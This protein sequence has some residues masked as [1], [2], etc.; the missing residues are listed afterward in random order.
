M[1]FLLDALVFLGAAILVVPVCQRLGMSTVLGYLI[2][3]LIIGPGVLGLIGE[4]KAADE[5]LHFAEIGV[6]L[7]LFVIGLELQPR[8]LWVMRN[9]VFGLGSLQIGT[10]TLVI[11]GLML[12][13]FGQT[14]Q[15]SLL[16]GFALALSSTAFVLQLLAERKTLNQPYGRASFA[17]LL[18]QDMAVIPA[19]AAL[20]LINPNTP[21]TGGREDLLLIAVVV[22]GLFGARLALRPLLRFV[23]GTGIRELFTAAALALVVGAA[24]TMQT[25]GLSMGL[26][27]FIAGMMVADSEYRHQLE[28]DVSPFKGMLLGLFFMAVGMS[29][30][31]R[32]LL[33]MPFLILGLTALLMVIKTLLLYPLARIMRMNHAEG[34]RAAAVLS[35]GGEF[36]FVLLTTATL[37][38]IIDSRT[39]DIAVLV[40][41]TSMMLTPLY[42]AAIERLLR[43]AAPSRPFDEITEPETP[44]VIAGFGRVGQIIGRIL[45]MRHIPFTA[46]ESSSSQ[47]E[48]VRQ[49]GNRIFYGDPTNLELLRSAHIAHAK[50]LIIAVDDADA[51]VRMA[52]SV[53]ASYPGMKIFA[54]ARNRRHELQLRDVGVD[55]V[56]RETLGSSLVMGTELL[57]VMGLSSA[58]AV[59]AID[60]F[61]EH[62]ERTLARQ[63]AVHRDDEAFRQAAIAADR[64][65]EEL[66]R[67]D[68]AASSETRRGKDGNLPQRS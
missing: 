1:T 47:V 49:F 5:V 18:M 53:R 45:T 42:S 12:L 44:V 50:V 66:F 10:T 55:F 56:I 32:L 23:A 43:S 65:L 7:L 54:R 20:D 3:G 57:K 8:R 22:A 62:D 30:D 21:S 11:S 25:I 29:V 35:Q 24:L 2:A 46:L 40:I 52:R 67:E 14:W 68:L 27:A 59:E 13:V 6:V 58:E 61:R 64:E 41:T 51:A 17:T 63:L 16:L 26:G 37:A 9:L 15:S 19:I 36:G 31:L 33:D 28:T 38:A 60:V 48:F 34:L 39:A 4:A